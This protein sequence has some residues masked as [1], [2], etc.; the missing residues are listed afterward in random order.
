MKIISRIKTRIN[1]LRRD[2]L[3]LKRFGSYFISWKTKLGFYLIIGSEIFK[4]YK[5]NVPE[6]LLIIGFAFMLLGIAHKTEGK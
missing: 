6:S 5:Y 1:I 3:G 4:F 2:G